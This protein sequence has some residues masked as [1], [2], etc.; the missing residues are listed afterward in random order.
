YENFPCRYLE[1]VSI[2]RGGVPVRYELKSSY[3]YLPDNPQGPLDI[4]YCYE[5]EA[6]FLPG[7]CEFKKGISARLMSFGVACEY[8]LSQGKYDEAAVW[9]EKF[10]DALRA[11][12]LL[13]R[14]LAMRSR[15]WA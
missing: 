7:D 8:C 15:R 13:R 2:T 4:E 10:R 6:K 3:I 9:E 5:P 1:L 11:A 14:T 12:G